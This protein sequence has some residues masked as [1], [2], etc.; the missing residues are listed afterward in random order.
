M[1]DVPYGPNHHYHCTPG[2]YLVCMNAC[3]KK[4]KDTR[5]LNLKA[6]YTTKAALRE[7]TQTHSKTNS[8]PHFVF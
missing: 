1:I 4:R 5:K 2:N 8:I 7:Q 6:R 3:S